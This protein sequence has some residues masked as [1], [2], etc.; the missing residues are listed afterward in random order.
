MFFEQILILRVILAVNDFRTFSFQ[1]SPDSGPVSQTCIVLNINRDGW[2]RSKFNRPSHNF[3]QKDA[4]IALDMT[5]SLIFNNFELKNPKH[6]RVGVSCLVNM[7]REALFWYQDRP[8]RLVW[9]FEAVK[10][11][12]TDIF[13]ENVGL[14]G[15]SHCLENDN[16]SLSWIWIQND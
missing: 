9:S 10:G 12:H 15:V 14:Q 6:V 4:L 2:G 7:I 8:R 16:I 5:V 1:D 11:N 13:H 3:N